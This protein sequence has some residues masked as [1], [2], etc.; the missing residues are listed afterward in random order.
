MADNRRDL[1][2][3]SSPEQELARRLEELGLALSEQERAEAE[4]DPTFARTLRAHLVH[5]EELAPHPSFARDLR[6][7]LQRP[8]ARRISR[9]V[10]VRL[11]TAAVA[12]AALL[13]AV[14]V[15]SR[16]F[17]PPPAPPFRAPSPTTADLVFAYPAPRT[18]IHHLTPTV[19]LVHPASGVAYRG[20][21]TLAAHSLPRGPSELR[22]YRLAPLSGI[23]SVGRILLHI[24]SPVRQVTTATGTW[25]VAADG[26]YPSRRPLHS[27]AVSLRTEELIYHDRR[28]LKL[29]RARAPLD[30]RHT[31]AAARAWLARLGLPGQRMPLRSFG[32]VP[33]L[34]KV[35][36]VSFDWIGVGRTAV[37]AATLWV[38]PDRS[39]IEAWVWPPL[40]HGGTLPTR[41]LSSAWGDVLK[42]RLPLAVEG[43]SPLLHAAGA[44]LL[45]RVSVVFV[46]VPEAKGQLFLVPTYRFE[47][48]VHISGASVH[49]WYTLAPSAGRQ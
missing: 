4:I 6:T 26:G 5:G 49:T 13:A 9:P 46:L 16:P 25:A 33:A 19:S 36:E 48:K 17:S 12:V 38:T 30:R 28:N 2:G 8:A 14:L 34:A 47:G 29:P 31:I 11:G 27:L 44:G 23:V 42:R 7:R 39:I 20:R 41:P 35:R 10:A 1:E 3:L 32:D 43:V 45:R 40:A 24:R 18:V 37:D 15:V 21:L 22:A